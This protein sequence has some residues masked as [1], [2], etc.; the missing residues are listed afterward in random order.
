[1]WKR[2]RDGER[3]GEREHEK[4]REREVIWRMKTSVR[5]N[6][7]RMKERE[8][9]KRMKDRQIDGDTQREKQGKR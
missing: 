8:M 7:I 5:H 4:E 2:E 6:R 1:V 3:V 9:R